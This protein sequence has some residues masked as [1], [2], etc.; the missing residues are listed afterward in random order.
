MGCFYNETISQEKLIE[1]LVEKRHNLI[2]SRKKE[3]EPFI[4][5]DNKTEK[6]QDEFYR[7]INNESKLINYLEILQK[8]K[9]Y[10][11]KFEYE[12]LFYFDVLSV[13]NRIKFTKICDFTPSIDIFGK[14]IDL[15]NDFEFEDI[16]E[17][18]YFKNPSDICGRE[19]LID[20]DNFSYKSTYLLQKREDNYLFLKNFLLKNIEKS[21]KKQKITIENPELYFNS[22]L[23]LYFQTIQKAD[24][25]RLQNICEIVSELYKPIFNYLVKINNKENFSKTD[26]RIMNILFFAPVIADNSLYDVNRIG[27]SF[28]EKDNLIYN[29][30]NSIN[31]S[32]TV[33]EKE[34]VIKYIHKHKNN[35]ITENLIKLS[36][37]WIYIIELLKKD[38]YDSRMKKNL[39][40]IDFI[41]CVKLHHFQENNFYTHNKIY[42]EFNKNIMKYILQ[43]KTIK[44]L[45]DDL[46]PKQCY[47]FENEE[48]IN[49]LF[50][51]II[52]VP[53]PTHDS[54][55]ITYKK[56]LI[57]FINGL[58][59]PSLGRIVFLSKSSSFIILGIHEG[60]FH[61]ASAFYCYLY[62]DQF[63]FK[64]VKFDKEILID[65]GII[66]KND[67]KE[68]SD[69]KIEELLKYDG[70]DI[71]EII[72]FG[73][74]LNF[75]TL[76][77]IL[78]L[79]CRKSY[80]CDYKSFRKKFKDINNENLF[81]LFEDIIKDPNLF[82]LMQILK[83]DLEFIKKLYQADKINFNF[84]R[85]GDIISNSKCGEFRF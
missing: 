75:F 19:K 21:R 61:W 1:I 41:K 37:P 65:I 60:C 76:N 58:A 77:E 72:L 48:N 78:F 82:H 27:Y 81:S 22:L 23:Q 45:F 44:T 5:V 56:G 15:L 66:D 73:R 13:N 39:T 43:S 80:D 12:L 32:L 59:N 71:L 29:T 52:F 17:L 9:N 16:K 55:G 28:E 54:Y 38:F 24:E 63:L 7:D 6:L 70:G 83:I 18:E 4:L 3:F 69:I 11:E 62:Q 14:L 35:K 51:D 25:S 85:N 57:I 47:I 31:C 84:K 20:S 36:N 8:K 49:T 26:I 50:D 67:K 46:Y 30:M 64:S 79:L 2:A 68:Y 34:L 74:K 33:S 42:W 10:R 40:E 53:F